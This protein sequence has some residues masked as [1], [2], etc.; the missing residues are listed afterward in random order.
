VA[1]TAMI[2]SWLSGTIRPSGASKL[3]NIRDEAVE[4]EKG[5]G[6]IRVVRV[7]AGALAGVVL[8]V[9]GACAH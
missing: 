7:V 5:I 3:Q 9:G 1:R 8:L 2:A 6:Q 4:D